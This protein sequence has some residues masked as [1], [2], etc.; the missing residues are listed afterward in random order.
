M[1]KEQNDKQNPSEWLLDKLSA[2]YGEA[3]EIVNDHLQT[4]KRE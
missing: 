2:I 4:L 1:P 3:S